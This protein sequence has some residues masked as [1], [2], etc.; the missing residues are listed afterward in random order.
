M[1]AVVRDVLW[2][3]EHVH[4]RG[5]LAGQEHASWT[6]VCL[7]WA[8][9]Q[10]QAPRSLVDM[11][12]RQRA[13]AREGRRYSHSKQVKQIRA[14][15]EHGP[16]DNKC[17]ALPA[18]MH[19]AVT[20]GQAVSSMTCFSS[21]LTAHPWSFCTCWQW[22]LHICAAARAP[23]AHLESA[24]QEASFLRHTC[25]RVCRARS[26]CTCVWSARKCGGGRA[27]ALLTGAASVRGGT[28]RRRRGR[29][30]S[31]SS[32]GQGD[33]ASEPACKKARPGVS[34]LGLATKQQPQKVQEPKWRATPRQRLDKLGL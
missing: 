15:H 25:L 2:L 18:E 34:Y 10:E 4:V 27:L 26:T 19:N 23:E 14:I 28:K 17:R 16:A 12:R 13:E 31:A 5:V 1:S 20:Q 32:T 24:W 33:R 7:V 22:Y 29:R 9:F 21:T 8:G 3:I 6:V 30:S 11:P